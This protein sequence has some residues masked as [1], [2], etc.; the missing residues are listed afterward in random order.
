M[1]VGSRVIRVGD[2]AISNAFSYSQCVTVRGEEG[3][4]SVTYGGEE[5]KDQMLMRGEEKKKG[6]GTPRIFNPTVA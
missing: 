1:L 5:N 3:T 6:L 4:A 2:I